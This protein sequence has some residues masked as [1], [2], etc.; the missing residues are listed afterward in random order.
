MIY[1]NLTQYDLPNDLEAFTFPMGEYNPRFNK[2]NDDLLIYFQWPNDLFKIA[3]IANA[4]NNNNTYYHDIKLYIPY[5]P[6]ARQDRICNEGEALSLEAILTYLSQ[7]DIEHIIS[8]DVHNETEFGYYGFHVDSI[9]QYT[10]SSEAVRRFKP[11]FLISPDKGATEKIKVLAE[12]TD[13]PIV[14][15]YK[16]RDP[17]TGKLSGF[18]TDDSIPTGRGLIVDDICD[19]GGTFLGLSKLFDNEL[20]LYVTHGGFTKGLQPLFDRFSEIYTTNSLNQTGD[21]LDRGYKKLKV[22][23]VWKEVDKFL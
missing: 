10:F 14:Q 4:F 8:C 16:V 3:L 1:A 15:C 21:P 6:Y 20:G 5:F 12:M 19:G 23:D 22:I 9:P 2:K 13:R 17:A 11:D 18:S 7:L